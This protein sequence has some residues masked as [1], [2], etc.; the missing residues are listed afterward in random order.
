M[1]IDIGGEYSISDRWII[2]ILDIEQ[3]TFKDSI[4]WDYIKYCDEQNQIEFIGKD[5]PKTVIVCLDKCYLS[6]LTQKSI[7]RQMQTAK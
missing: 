7:I 2:A 3:T 6:P 4:T 5:I 1:Y